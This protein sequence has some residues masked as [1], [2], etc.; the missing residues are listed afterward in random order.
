MI[1]DTIKSNLIVGIM[2]L[3][4]DCAPTKWSTEMPNK[5]FYEKQQQHLDGW[6]ASTFRERRQWAHETW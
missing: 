4:F 1:I 3:F 6:N 5:I 2:L